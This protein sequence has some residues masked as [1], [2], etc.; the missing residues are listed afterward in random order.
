MDVSRKREPYRGRLVLIHGD[1]IVHR[2]LAVVDSLGSASLPPV[3]DERRILLNGLADAVVR[4]RRRFGRGER[5]SDSS[6]A[7]PNGHLR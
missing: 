7:E 4:R 2:A 3:R 1:A 5:G 6:F